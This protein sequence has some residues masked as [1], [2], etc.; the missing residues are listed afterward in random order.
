M[1]RILN[2]LLDSVFVLSGITSKGDWSHFTRLID[3]S[4]ELWDIFTE[5][6]T[7]VDK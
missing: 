1:Y 7:H 3:T 5:I 4:E 2:Q 6:E